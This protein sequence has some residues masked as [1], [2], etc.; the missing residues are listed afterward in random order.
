MLLD[1]HSI[2]SEVPRFFAGRLPDF[3]LGTAG[4][5]S[6]VG[7]LAQSV[8]AVL[9]QADGFTAVHNG[10]FKG[11]YITRHYGSPGDGVHAMQLEMAQRAYMDETRPRDYNAARAAPLTA[12]LKTLV[13]QMLAWRPASDA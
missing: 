12:I 2:I 13:A 10:R 3:N 6:C 7:G 11:G 8:F 5:S 4:G 9:S 1:G